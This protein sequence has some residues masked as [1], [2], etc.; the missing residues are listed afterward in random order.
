VSGD[1][2]F[3]Q[4]LRE[5]LRGLSEFLSTEMRDAGEGSDPGDAPPVVDRAAEQTPWVVLARVEGDDSI[6][7]A[8]DRLTAADLQRMAESYDPMHRKAPV[9]LTH[10]GDT[11]AGFIEETGFDGANLLGRISEIP[12]ADGEGLVTKAVAKGWIQRSIRFWRNSPE[13]EGNPPQLIHLA[14][15]GGEAPG[16][17]SL[18]PLDLAFSRSLPAGAEIFSDRSLLDEPETKE[19]EDMDENKIAELVTSAVR[20]AVAPLEQRVADAE[21][22]AADNA[23]EATEAREA[24][25]K[26]TLEGELRQLVVDGR[27]TPAE[28]DGEL[29]V[30][31][32]LPGDLAEKRLGTLRTRARLMRSASVELVTQ[33]GDVV[34]NDRRFSSDAGTGVDPDKLQIV[35]EAERKAGGDFAK[36]RAE[37]YARHGEPL[38]GLPAAN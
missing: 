31:L 8:K 14:L 24:S 27:V 28:K 38:T 10:K 20:A 17:H 12:D 26:A 37:L 3:S 36:F 33:S 6:I 22:L 16:Q 18:P 29:E 2:T 9:V 30:L 21:K 1:T 11:P 35:H 13:I 15:L 25:R 5:K 7:P 19:T 32:A 34:E 23:K 4:R